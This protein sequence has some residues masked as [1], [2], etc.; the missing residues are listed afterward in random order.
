MT[1]RGP[2]AGPYLQDTTAWTIGRIFEF[3]GQVS[4]ANLAVVSTGNLNE[5]LKVLVEALVDQPHV[6]GKACWAGAYTR[7]PFSST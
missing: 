6:A 4:N 2:S 1:W 7:L 5:I 3:V